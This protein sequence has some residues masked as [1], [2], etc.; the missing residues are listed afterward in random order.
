[1]LQGLHG[2]SD[3]MVRCVNPA[4]RSKSSRN[5]S[6]SSSSGAPNAGCASSSAGSALPSI[7]ASSSAACASSSAR[8]RKARSSFD[9]MPAL[10]GSGGS[11]SGPIAFR[12][13][14]VPVTSVG[15]VVRGT[16]NLTAAHAAARGQTSGQ[17]V[18]RFYMRAKR[19]TRPGA[20]GT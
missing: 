10:G 20:Q 8:K 1:M 13:T 12:T 2:A 16:L 15:K 4:G 5:C 7:C 14:P 19:H 18:E 11:P 6:T 3:A 17:K 9:F